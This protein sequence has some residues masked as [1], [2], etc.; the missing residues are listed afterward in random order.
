MQRLRDLLSTVLDS[1]LN[2]IVIS[3]TRVK[4]NPVRKIKYRPVV[5][6]G[7]IVFQETKTNGTQEFHKNL[8]K[9]EALEMILEMLEK[10]YVQIEVNHSSLNAT[11]LINKKGGL[12][13]KIK[14]KTITQSENTVSLSDSYLKRLSHNKKK[15]YIIEEGVAVPFLV[16]LGVMT[17]DGRIVNK[18]YDK[19]RQ[20]N[21]F[22]EFVEDIVAELPRD[23]EISIIDFG[24]GKSYLTFALYYYLKVLQGVDIR[25]TGL[26]LKETVIDNCNELSKK[27]GY[28]K[29][30]FLCGDI[31]TYDKTN[32]VDMV[33]TLHAC[34]TATDY[35]LY[36][37]VNWGAKVIL[38]VPCCQHEMN[39]Q[40]QS[41]LLNPVLKYGL[42]KERMS[43][44][45]T[46]AVRARY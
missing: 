19:F 4:D 25:I 30:E 14:N 35:A 31:A 18:R 15:K 26:D 38:S 5:I 17:K 37:A 1:G 28:D 20:I 42:I 12:A 33:V 9:S 6:K 3:H 13:L 7:N 44:L 27:Y 11:G 29:L 10:D 43:A 46:D 41:D 16:D 32:S 36:K 34:D 22:L 2:S 21:R 23:R 39:G 45:I 24:C 40:I 8:E